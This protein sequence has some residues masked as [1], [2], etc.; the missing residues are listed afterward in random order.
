MAEKENLQV[1]N[2]ATQHQGESKFVFIN[3]LRGH[4]DPEKK[5]QN[6]A[7]PWKD[8]KEGKAFI[9]VFQNQIH[10]VKDSNNKKIN[11]MLG[12]DVQVG[13][14]DKEGQRQNVTMSP[15][16]IAHEVQESR[17]FQKQEYFKSKQA[18]K[19]NEKTEAWTPGEK[20]N[21]WKP[22]EEKSK[23]NDIAIDSSDLPF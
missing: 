7:I 5:T 18:E 23:D 6:V 3:G 10:E 2:E 20:S 17:K 4:K 11:V 9:R 21:A 1:E 13:F 15:K 22:K 8:A 12:K 16:D 19:G 14:I